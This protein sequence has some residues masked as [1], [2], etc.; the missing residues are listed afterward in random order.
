MD[1]KERLAEYAAWTQQGLEEYLAPQPGLL[2]RVMESARYSALAGGKRLR[3]ALLMEFYR[4][5]GGEPRQALPFAC[6]LEMIHTYSLIHDDLPCMDNDDLRRGKPTNH[7]VYGEAMAL[8]AGDGL[9]TRAFETMLAP[10]AAG[11]QPQWALEAAGILASCAGMEGMI[12]GQVMD[13]AFEETVPGGEDL[14]RMVELKTGCLLRA[15]CVGGCA[16][17]G[18]HGAI[19]Q[20]ATAYAH[21]LGLAFQIQDDIL[22][23]TGQQETLGKTIGSDAQNHKNTFVRIYGLEACRR[24]VDELTCQAVA[25]VEPL[26]DSGFL[27]QLA[28]D[29]ARRD[30]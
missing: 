9:L 12:G 7:K 21:A 4:L 17:A 3:P 11:I 29:L 23:V 13:L 24:R 10:G 6:A 18:E 27:Q 1:C 8:L 2:G 22:D 14:Q 5:C 15:A 20:G 25:A 19:R 28:R 16:L 30:H 26:E